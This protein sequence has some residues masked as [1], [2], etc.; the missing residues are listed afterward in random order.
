MHDSVSGPQ[1]DADRRRSLWT[2]PS[3]PDWVRRL[4]QEGRCLD[5]QSVV[6]LDE[7]SLLQAAV[8]NTGLTDFGSDDWREPFQVLL[9]ALEEEA[10]L[11]LTGRIMT[12]S[13]L[14]TFLE[15]RLRIEDC[16]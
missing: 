2:P 9:R 7:R 10:E 14:L 6:P 15:A 8:R 3:R 1:G 4:N 13:D 5:L 12:R 11:S 16:Y